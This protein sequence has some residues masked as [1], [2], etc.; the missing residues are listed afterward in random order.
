ML[1][2]CLRVDNP[3]NVSSALD[4]AELCRPSFTLSRFVFDFFQTKCFPNICTTDSLVYFYFHSLSRFSSF[5]ADIYS[6]LCDKSHASTMNADYKRKMG[7]V[8]VAG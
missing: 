1:Y 5:Q 6:C 4:S 7:R 3:S 8:A 2:F